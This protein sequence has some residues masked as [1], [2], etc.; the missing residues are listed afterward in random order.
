MIKPYLLNMNA[1]IH[2]LNSS[3]KLHS[4]TFI[5]L[6]KFPKNPHTNKNKNKTCKFTVSDYL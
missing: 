3:K 4:L 5:F 2:A 6:Q 1:Q